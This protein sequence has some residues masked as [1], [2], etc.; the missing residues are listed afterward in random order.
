[1]AINGCVM[2]HLIRKRRM[3]TNMVKVSY[4]LALAG[5]KLAM[6]NQGMTL[7]KPDLLKVNNYAA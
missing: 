2:L 7:L 4:L 1:M 6:L 5:R 3:L